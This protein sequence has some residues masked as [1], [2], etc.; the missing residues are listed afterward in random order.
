[1]LT[2]TSR[3][4]S[5]SAS[6]LQGQVASFV[7]PLLD[8]LILTGLLTQPLT[9]LPDMGIK[10]Y[11]YVLAVVAEP[12]LVWIETVVLMRVIGAIGKRVSRL[13]HSHEGE[14]NAGSAIHI[15]M[16]LL[17]CAIYYL[18]IRILLTAMSVAS[19]PVFTQ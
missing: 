17:T 7:T 14:E 5:K 3:L 16:I 9:L 10:V 1:M 6:R 19:S 12:V 15:L 18:S 8:L 2:I 11:T 4:I 13:V